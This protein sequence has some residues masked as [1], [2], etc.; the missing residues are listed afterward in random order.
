MNGL[1]TSL[2]STRF[3]LL[4]MA[5]LGLGAAL[6]YDNPAGT[7]VWVLVVPMALLAVNLFFAILVNPRINRR[8]GLL[9][10]HIGLLGVVVLAAIGRLTHMEAHLELVEGTAFETADLMNI[11]QGP[12]HDG[13]LDR[14]RFVQ[15]NYTVDY[16]SG[17]VRGLT[18]SQV[19]EIDNNGKWIEHDVGDDR[20]LI[21]EGY[22]F[23]TT[24]NKG[25]AAILTWTADDGEPVTGAVNMP[26]Y[27]MFD[28]R[29][30]NTWTPPG[31]EEIRFWLQ[32]DTGLTGEA[33][34]QLDIR[35]SQG[36]LVVNSAGK[37]VELAPGE[38]LRM[39]GGELRYERLAGWMGY[40]LY[41]DPTLQWLF[42]ISILGVIGLFIHYWQKLS[43][44]VPLELQAG[45]KP[46]VPAD[47]CNVSKR[48]S[49][50]RDSGGRH[51]EAMT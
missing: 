39:N 36:R 32:L 19:F 3:T 25:F 1:F 28:F 43:T 17:M 4:G 33:P 51:S 10:F 9:L 46:A 34:W 47:S 11:K 41:Y 8:F 21:I 15:G 18:H 27:P 6:S 22:R 40:K 48:D 29:Q 30:S 5:L 44:G 13:R 31:G 37:R 50:S 2:S 49:N 7:P 26:S 35:Q 42:F 16:E 38:A 23:Y 24:F 14:V 12:L 20:P 45:D